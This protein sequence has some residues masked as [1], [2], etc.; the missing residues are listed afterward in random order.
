VGFGR[1]LIEFRLKR[2]GR[3]TLAITVKPDTSVVVTAPVGVGVEAVKAR[4]RKRAMW[5][6]RQQEYF[7]RFLPK[8]PPRRY[9]SGETHRYLGRQYGPAFYRLLRRVMPDWEERKD[10]LERAAAE[11]GSEASA[12]GTPETLDHTHRTEGGGPR[13]N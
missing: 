4:I 6:R 9:V 1:G 3:R 12:C 8:L 11:T 2:T 7:G 13:D 5:V 10:R